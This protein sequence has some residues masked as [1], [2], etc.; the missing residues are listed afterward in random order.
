MAAPPF[1]LPSLTARLYRFQGLVFPAIKLLTNIIQQRDRRRVAWAWGQGWPG[2]QPPLNR[3]RL[4][5]IATNACSTAAS[6]RLTVGHGG[7][8][9][10]PLGGSLG[11]L[12]LDLCQVLYGL[13]RLHDRL[14][15]LLGWPDR[16]GPRSLDLHGL[17]GL[18]NNH[19]RCLRRSGNC[20][21]LSPNA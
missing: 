17:C 21:R 4:R 13:R 15:R 5:V 19:G 6:S 16:L 10:R 7:R 8:L 14:R 9:F 3:P 12:A 1:C 18:P 11:L 20:R 2:R